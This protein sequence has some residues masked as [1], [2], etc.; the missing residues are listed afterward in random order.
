M[1]K[2]IMIRMYRGRRFWECPHC[3]VETE[4]KRLR[5]TEWTCLGCLVDKENQGN[6]I[7]VTDNFARCACRKCMEESRNVARHFRNMPRLSIDPDDLTKTRLR[8]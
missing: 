2:N 6:C 5:G 8:R 4:I 1:S 3:K 7:I